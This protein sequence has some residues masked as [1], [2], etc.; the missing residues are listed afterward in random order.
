MWKINLDTIKKCEDLARICQK[1]Q[2]KI[3]VDICYGRYLVDG[4]S[5]LGVMSLLLHEAEIW[6]PKTDEIVTKKFEEEIAEIGAWKE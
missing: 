4:C 5:V 1:Y 6:I 2:N 3:N